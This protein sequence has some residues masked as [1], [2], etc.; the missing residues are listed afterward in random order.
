S[1]QEDGAGIDGKGEKIS[2]RNGRGGIVLQ[3]CYG[4]LAGTSQVKGGQPAV[5]AR[6]D[7]RRTGRATRGKLIYSS[8]YSTSCSTKCPTTTLSSSAPATM[9]SPAQ[10][11][12]RWPGCA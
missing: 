9:A 8:I 5:A 10:P 6:L 4:H 3:R 2:P 11:I 1:A 7:H 12:L